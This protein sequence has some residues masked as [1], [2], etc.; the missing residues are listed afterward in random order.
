MHYGSWVTWALPHNALVSDVKNSSR[1]V[2]EVTLPG[3]HVGIVFE[4]LYMLNIGLK[5]VIFKRPILNDTCVENPSLH[6]DE[7]LVLCLARETT[8]RDLAFL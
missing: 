8:K 2:V 3:D 6:D 5:I 4:V 7:A 1:H